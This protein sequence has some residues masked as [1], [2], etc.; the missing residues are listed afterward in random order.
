MRISA[1]TLIAV[2]Q[3]TAL[4]SAQY[5]S[6][7]V[8]V[9]F[10]MFKGADNLDKAIEDFL[11][12]SGEYQPACMDP[13][14]NYITCITVPDD[15]EET[16]FLVSPT[17]PPGTQLKDL[18]G[19][20]DYDLGTGLIEAFT[21]SA[22]SSDCNDVGD[23]ALATYQWLSGSD[24]KTP[25]TVTSLVKDFHSDDNW[26]EDRNRKL[27]DDDF[28]RYICGTGP[29]TEAAQEMF[30]SSVMDGSFQNVLGSSKVAFA[31]K[32]LDK[33]ISAIQV[34]KPDDVQP[35]CM[36]PVRNYVSC[37]SL[38]EDINETAFVAHPL[39]PSGTKLGDIKGS[40]YDL[41]KGM[42][43][44]LQAAVS[45][46]DCREVGNVGLASYG[47]LSSVD[48]KSPITATTFVKDFIVDDKGRRLG[49]RRIQKMDKYVCSTSPL[50]PGGEATDALRATSEIMRAADN[51]QAA[52]LSF[53]DIET[54]AQPGCVDALE[55][56]ITC[57]DV[58]EDIDDTIFIAHP[59]VPSG[60]TL[61]SIK[62]TP[63]YDLGKGLIN[64]FIGATSCST[65]SNYGLATYD[66]FSAKDGTTPI[67]ATSIVMNFKG[68]KDMWKMSDKEMMD[69]NDWEAMTYV[70][71][72]E[73]LN[74]FP[75]DM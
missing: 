25:V 36:D 41:A 31:E 9:A 73:P 34:G 2:L 60:T 54:P 11:F 1:A 48:F 47:W 67:S 17:V 12:E 16:T 37:L 22:I 70:C 43:D 30:G 35:A 5:S 39:V 71:G 10:E 49:S 6:D 58:Q 32:N 14:D 74:E 44:A 13:V 46:N 28:T 7:V 19:T 50:T 75:R 55:N 62:G 66:W 52:V 24:F 51:I 56:Y 20:P 61:G 53:L 68:F 72:S 69:N 40:D 42:I 21:T 18:M 8:D 38:S 65:D 57:I 45:P 33:A 59:I 63:D 23:F 64:A 27:E 26:G 29:L 4:T 15:I 3:I